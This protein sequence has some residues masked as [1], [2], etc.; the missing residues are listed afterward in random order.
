MFIC[1]S[2]GN[3]AFREGRGHAARKKKTGVSEQRRWP[4]EVRVLYAKMEAKGN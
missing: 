2:L 4:K 1:L 3:F